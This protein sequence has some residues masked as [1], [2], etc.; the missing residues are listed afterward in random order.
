M[1]REQ[2]FY[3]IRLL[4]ICEWEVAEWS[5][6]VWWVTASDEPL[7]ESDLAEIDEERLVHGLRTIHSR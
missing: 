5:S 6:K 1:V 4:D 3:W 2:G 7:Q